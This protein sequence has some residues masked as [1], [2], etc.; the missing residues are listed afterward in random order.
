MKSERLLKIYARLKRSPATIEMLQEWA[1][2]NGIEIS[3]RTLYRD[4]QHLENFMLLDGERLVVSKG[5]K[6]KK[7]WKIEFRG[8]DRLTEFDINSYLLFTN[9]LPRSIAESRTA[10]LDR[11]KE[12]YYQT[13]SKSRFQD[14]ASYAIDQLKSTRFGE[15]QGNEHYAKTLEDMLWSMRNRRELDI[16]K[17]DLDITSL[18]R[19]VL[20]PMKFL[21]VKLVYHRGV[22]HLGGFDKKSKKLILLALSQITE[23]K[24]TNIPF[25]NTLLLKKYEDEIIKRFGI[26]ENQ[27]D[28][29]YDIELEFSEILGHFVKNDY[30]HPTQKC[31]Q[32]ENGNFIMTMR[33]GINREL[34]GWIFMWMTNVRVLKPKILKDI[35]LKKC[36]EILSDYESAKPLISNNTF[37]AL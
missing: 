28:E 24:L 3:D 11:I 21:P 6:N 37:R 35:M 20:F 32:K 19:S 25:K 16:R 26:T 18:S 7:T 29:V 23:Y 36:Q 31:I 33:C 1:C 10:S 5:E 8:N 34:V 27:D 9:F 12:V 15:F 14:F 2:R 4:M 30:W 17:V 22:V 13:Y